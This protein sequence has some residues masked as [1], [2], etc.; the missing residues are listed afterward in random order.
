MYS[1]ENDIVELA[2]AVYLDLHYIYVYLEWMYTNIHS[3]MYTYIY[4]LI[5]TYNCTDV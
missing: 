1:I 3:T 5:Y 4:I 2:L